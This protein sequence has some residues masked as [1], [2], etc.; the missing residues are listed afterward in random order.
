MWNI[1]KIILP[2]HLIF[3]PLMAISLAILMVQFFSY[4]CV[5][6]F[7]IGQYPLEIK[8]EDF[9]HLNNILNILVDNLK[10]KVKILP[11][12]WVYHYVKKLQRIFTSVMQQRR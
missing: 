10:S 5:L 8:L 7:Y 11:Y 4:I 1:I 6:A 9:D 3:L 12:Q 2:L